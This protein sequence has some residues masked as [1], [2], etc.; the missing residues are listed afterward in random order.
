[1]YAAYDTLVFLV[2]SFKLVFQTIVDETWGGRVRCF[3]TGGGLPWLSKGL[4][5][6]GQVYYM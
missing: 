3:F 5:Q 2:I 1:M 4:L 6:G